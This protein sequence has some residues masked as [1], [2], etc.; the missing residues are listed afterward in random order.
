MALNTELLDI[1]ACPKCHGDLVL[2]P[3]QDGL[4]CEKCAV[5]YP[6]RDEIPIMLVEEAI[7][8]DEW[9]AKRPSAQ[10]GE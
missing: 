6:I 1:L 7:P 8:L 2:T 5:V 3:E 10:G 4:I 9:E